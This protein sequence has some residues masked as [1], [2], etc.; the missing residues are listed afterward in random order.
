MKA[1]LLDVPCRHSK[2]AAH[3]GMFGIAAV[4]QSAVPIDLPMW[5]HDGSQDTMPRLDAAE[6]LFRRDGASR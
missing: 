6:P 1:A 2:F 3:R 4:H 5:H